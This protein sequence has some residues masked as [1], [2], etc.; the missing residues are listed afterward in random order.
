MTGTISPLW[1]PAI[2]AYLGI[3]WAAVFHRFWGR[4]RYHLASVDYW[5]SCG[6]FVALALMITLP[7]PPVATEI[8]RLTG[9]IG[10]AD[11]LA[12][13]AALAAILAWLV[14]LSRLVP[15]E[16]RWIIDEARGRWIPWRALI[17]LFVVSAVGFVG[18]FV[19]APGLL[20]FRLGPHPDAAQY[21]LTAIHLLYRA[22]CLLLLGLVIVVLR[23]LA[24]V[25]D[26]HVALAVRLQ[27]IRAILWYMLLYIVYEAASTLLWQL[28]DLSSRIFRLRSLLLL[29]A[30]V[31]P[32]RWY[33]VGL[34]RFQTL[35]ASFHS[36]LDSWRDW[37]AYRTLFPLWAA[38]YPLRPDNS[39]LR[40]PISRYAWWPSRPLRLVLCRMIVEIHDRSIELWAYQ[41]PHAA[42]VAE[43][44]ADEAA[45]PN[46]ARTALV[47]AVVLAEALANWRAARPG[48][49]EATFPRADRALGDGT[50]LREEVAALVP[51]ARAFARS[52]LIAEA[53]A[54]LGQGRHPT[55]GHQSDGSRPETA[56]LI[57]DTAKQR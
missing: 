47:E 40:P 7:L 25:V 38:L 3:A 46:N 42:I 53:L 33:L 45:L 29:S 49:A 11:T 17:G 22:V 18:R 2:A 57:V 41:S 27:V 13:A 54:R 9:L 10:L 51:V 5:S 21:Y 19:W 32:N 48:E 34:A 1:L 55:C 31:A 12:D 56:D 26:T 8:D 14:Y 39:H 35:T 24:T 43:V 30:I 44:I 16:R 28:P 4:R 23:R 36:L 52:P 15:T 6:G 37:R 50:T 20:G